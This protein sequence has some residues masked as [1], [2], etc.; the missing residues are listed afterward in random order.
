M[1]I[2]TNSLLIAQHRFGIIVPNHDR[3]RIGQ[4]EVSR[5]STCY[6]FS[7]TDPKVGLAALA[8]VDTDRVFEISNN[9]LV[10]YLQK[11]GVQ[12]AWI[13]TANLHKPSSGNRRRRSQR[14]AS[15]EDLIRRLAQA[16]IPVR[17]GAYEDI[18]DVKTGH[19]VI[20]SPISGLR[21]VPGNELQSSSNQRV[22]AFL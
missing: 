2:K 10:D 8:H 21:I 5:P 14:E 13:Q 22:R 19:G 15:L 7:I 4:L 6:A 17:G 11:F 3:N 9:T 20:V 12:E 16:K 18:G 1:E